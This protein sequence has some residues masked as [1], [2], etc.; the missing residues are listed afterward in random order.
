MQ[1]LGIVGGI[2]SGKTLVSEVF[3]ELGA[4]VLSGDR[5]AH[6][7]LSEPVVLAAARD[8]WGDLVLDERGQVDRSQLAA[9]VFGETPTAREELGFLENLT[10]PQV[11]ERICQALEQLREE[12]VGVVLLDVALLLKTDWNPLCEKI[13]FLDT[14]LKRRQEYAALRGWDAG[15]LARREA[16]QLPLESKRSQADFV[17]HNSGDLVRLREEIRRVWDSLFGPQMPN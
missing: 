8:R 9:I 15:Q 10:H 13:I 12:E 11:H 4:V 16:C 6:E 17:L 7:V 3:G 1:V 2:A 5:I 14:P